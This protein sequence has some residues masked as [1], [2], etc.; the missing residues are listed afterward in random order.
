MNMYLLFTNFLN[1]LSIYLCAQVHNG[2]SVSAPL[3][4]RYCGTS[5]PG[6]IVSTTNQL[7]LQFGSDTSNTGHGF[8]AQYSVNMNGGGGGGGSSSGGGSSGATNTTTVMSSKCVCYSEILNLDI[9]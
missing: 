3:I 9:F 5:V 8:R 6:P 1:C 4:G 2:G 7:W